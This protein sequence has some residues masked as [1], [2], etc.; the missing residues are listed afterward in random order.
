MAPQVRQAAAERW[1]QERLRARADRMLG[2]TGQDMTPAEHLLAELHRSAAL[3]EIYG[4]LV[5][6]LDAREQEIDRH[7]QPSFADGLLTPHIGLRGARHAELHPFVALYERER[8]RRA[9]IAKLAIDAGVAEATVAL[10]ERTSGIIVAAFTAALA[11]EDMGLD[12]AQQ[13]TGRAVIARHLRAIDA[14]G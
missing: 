12:E 4:G 9:R 6:K 2:A 10:A 8:E 1:K 11:D 13:Q 14:E 7:D 5:A 3:C